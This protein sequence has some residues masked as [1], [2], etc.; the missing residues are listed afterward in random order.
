MIGVILKSSE[1]ELAEEFFQLF[2]TPWEIYREGKSYDVVVATDDRMPTIP[3]KLLVVYGS[4]KRGSDA[5]TNMAV[6]SRFAKIVLNYA[7]FELPV[8]GDVLTFDPARS[9]APVLT[10]VS[11]VAGFLADMAGVRVLRVGYDLFREVDH[12]LTIGQPQELS[13]VPALEIHVKV[14][15]DGILA[16]GM[17]LLEIPPMPSGYKFLICLTHDIDFVGIRNHRFD[18]TMWGFV[19]RST[20]GGLLDW[21]RRRISFGRLLRMWKSAASLPFVYVGLIRDFWLPFEWYLE[22]ERNLPTTYFLIPFKNRPGDNLSM[23]HSKRRAT[24]YDISDIPDWTTT[25]VSAGSEV[26]VHGIDAWHSVEKAKEEMLRIT[27]ITRASDIG[28]RMHW[29][30]RDENTYQVLDRAGY[31]YDSTAGYNETIG[32]RCGTTQVF[33]PLGTARLLELPLHI[34]DGALFFPQQLGLTEPEAWSKCMAMVQRAREL[35]GVL[36]IL[37]HDRSHGPERF[38]GEFY[39]RLLDE[40]RA[41][42][43]W[44]GNASQVVQ[45]FRNR[46]GVRFTEVESADGG[47][48]LLLSY[49][50]ANIVPPLTVRAYRAAAESGKLSDQASRITDLSWSGEARMTFT[51]Q[52]SLFAHSTCKVALNRPGFSGDLRV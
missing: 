23:R 42:D 6:A 38:W 28:V 46:R 30:M 20:V 26:G 52:S 44:F 15:R 8:Y 22:V 49:E 33:R 36:T 12:L 5:Q 14:L 9:V 13:H 50:G 10:T 19:Y 4:E 37:W 27:T 48:D 1:A 2:K 45:W 3:P 32:Y 25:L 24:K 17:P 18:H 43:G 31:V 35:G 40:L 16:A 51:P 41:S 47:V 34:Q 29:L 7:G 21:F 39:V 11:Q